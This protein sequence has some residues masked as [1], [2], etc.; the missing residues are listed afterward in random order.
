MLGAFTI[1]GIRRHWGEFGVAAGGNYGYFGGRLLTV[2][3]RV[4]SAR[5]GSRFSRMGRLRRAV[6]R[7]QVELCDLFAGWWDGVGLCGSAVLCNQW[8]RFMSPD[9]YQASGGVGDPASWNRYRTSEVTPLTILTRLVW[10]SVR[11]DRLTRA[12][13]SRHHFHLTLIACTIYYSVL[14]QYE[15]L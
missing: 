3:D 9:P 6:H 7:R 15:Y 2:Q 12:L 1:Q 5:Q 10:T 14:A 11:L 4:G 13:M 8:G